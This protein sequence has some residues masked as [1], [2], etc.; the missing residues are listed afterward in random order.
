MTCKEIT[1][2][3]VCGYVRGYQYGTLDGFNINPPNQSG[4]YVDGV[5]ITYD[6][7]P[8]HLWTYAAGLQEANSM[9]GDP[10][11]TVI[12]VSLPSLY[13]MVNNADARNLIVT[14]LDCP[15]STRHYQP[16]PLPLSL[17]VSV[18]MKNY[19]VELLCTCSEQALRSTTQVRY[20]RPCHCFDKYRKM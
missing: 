5:S 8:H 20:H 9:P 14:T 12:P 1:C 3:Q 18:W 19:Q 16:L 7:P 11:D 15:G 2:S 6:T 10:V 13:G 4:F 17:H